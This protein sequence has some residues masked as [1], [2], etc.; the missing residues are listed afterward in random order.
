MPLGARCRR[1][2]SAG[3]QGEGAASLF[4]APQ[5]DE[6]ALGDVDMS[7]TDDSQRTTR[8]RS[9]SS[10]TPGARLGGAACAC[11]GARAARPGDRACA[12]HDVPSFAE[13]LSDDELDELWEE[14]RGRDMVQPGESLYS[15]A[16]RLLLAA[17]H[18]QR[19]SADRSPPP[20]RYIR[21]GRAA[22]TKDMEAGAGKGL[23][24]LHAKYQ[25]ALH[26][27]VLHPTGCW[28][29]AVDMAK[30]EQMQTRG[31]STTEMLAEVERQRAEYV[32][33]HANIRLPPLPLAFVVTKS[34]GSREEVT[35]EAAQAL[36]T[37]AD[38]VVHVGMCQK[39]NAPGHAGN[40]FFGELAPTAN[41]SWAATTSTAEAADAL[42]RQQTSD[43][44]AATGIS[45][46]S[47][48]F[49]Q[50]PACRSIVDACGDSKS[51]S[52]IEHCVPFDREWPS[53][54]AAVEQV[55]ARRA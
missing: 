28:S 22:V 36:L 10:G 24:D 11:A 55:G 39:K 32:S 27:V 51:R 49:N 16:L 37:E 45:T 33:T 1:K 15:A 46:I 6:P 35:P 18:S 54:A 13:A 5:P 30:I 47:I 43:T 8:S 4:T 40:E 19:P 50:R 52:L 14:M 42:Y 7:A 34:D 12:E 25:N 31:A 53:E 9:T 23:R 29:E 26:T 38:V 2:A 3:P 17:E 48:E 41:G 44:A 21:S 20:Q